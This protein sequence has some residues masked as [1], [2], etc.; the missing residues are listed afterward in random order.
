ML[1]LKKKQQKTNDN[2]WGE[3]L[4]WNSETGLKK[5]LAIQVPSW[6]GKIYTY[7]SL[8]RTPKQKRFTLLNNSTHFVFVYPITIVMS[9]GPCFHVSELDEH[10]L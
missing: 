2:R 4:R 1:I 9:Q 10:P 8:P 6:N 5:I 7:S 3:K